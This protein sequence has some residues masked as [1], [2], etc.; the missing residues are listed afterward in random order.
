MA[1]IAEIVLLKDVDELSSLN[2]IWGNTIAFGLSSSNTS[3][4][5]VNSN[6]FKY[7]V[8]VSVQTCD[9]ENMN[10]GV[11]STPPRPRDLSGFQNGYGAI[12][13]GPIIKSTLFTT[14]TGDPGQEVYGITQAQMSKEYRYPDFKFPVVRYSWFGGYSYNPDL[15]VE[16]IIVNTAGQDY[17]GFSMSVP[18]PFYTSGQIFVVSD[19]PYISGYFIV[20]GNGFGTYSFATTTLFTTEMSSATN[21]AFITQ[22]LSAPDLYTG[23][24]YG[25]DGTQDYKQYDVSYNYLIFD[26]T[27]YNAPDGGNFNFL[28][29]YP[30]RRTGTSSVFGSG[31]GNLLGE[32]ISISKRVRRNTY[33][34]ISVIV[35]GVISTGN[36]VYAEY[37]TY[38][39]NFSYLNS[40]YVLASNAPF[41]PEG[42]K[43]CRIDFPL[44]T[45]NMNF[46]SNVKY[47]SIQLVEETGISSYDPWS[48]LRY[49]YIDDICSIYDDKQLMF[50]NR[51]G[52]WEYF[53]FTQDKKKT[54]R[55]KRNQIK[56]EFNWGEITNGNIKGSRGDTL[57]S[58]EVDVEFTLNSNWISEVEFEWLSELIE[59]NDVYILESYIGESKPYPVP[60]IITD[61][62]YEYKTAYRDQIFNLTLNYRYA[63]QK[64]IQTQ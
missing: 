24:K 50:K 64:G 43:L 23:Q 36:S 26:L 18:N 16:A 47:F 58:S 59:S 15:S 21:Q 6:S 2:D 39:A 32:C 28:S 5:S 62:N 51:F 38:D 49:F 41:C 63:A 33:E 25:F 40:Y 30:N 13:I 19:N 31:G 17:L 60:I 52:A 3:L 44:G 46:P 42:G 22:Y 10:F 56:K 54:D 37:K 12:S 48:E 20:N 9:D 55:I 53:T 57:I 45:I 35:D 29:N 34:T 1:K 4:I 27:L 8:E 11:F 14:P 61:T 7:Y